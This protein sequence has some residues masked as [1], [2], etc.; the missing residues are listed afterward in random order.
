MCPLTL[1]GK[2]STALILP[3]A[4]KEKQLLSNLTNFTLKSEYG[5]EITSVTD[6][7]MEIS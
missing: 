2:A 4:T 1:Q 3:L 6:A 5:V 7:R